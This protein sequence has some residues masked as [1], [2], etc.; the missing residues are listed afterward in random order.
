[1]KQ[2]KKAINIGTGILLIIIGAMSIVAFGSVVNIITNSVLLQIIFMIYALYIY[3]VNSNTQNHIKI[4][5]SSA[6]FLITV[7]IFTA[8]SF[9]FVNY[10]DVIIWS[11]FLIPPLSFLFTYLCDKEEKLFLKLSVFWI[12]F[13]GIAVFFLPSG[14]IN[15]LAQN[16]L[17][18]LLNAFP[19]L[20]VALGVLTI[21]KQSKKSL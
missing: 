16:F 7:A 6:G 11:V 15:S 9:K 1:M 18:V 12:L 10:N 5:L 14:F 17:S 20:L 8:N 4:F 2:L 19:F 21:S 13:G 3:Y